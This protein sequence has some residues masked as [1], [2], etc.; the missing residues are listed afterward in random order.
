MKSSE[1]QVV[2]TIKIPGTTLKTRPV[3]QLRRFKG[4]SEHLTDSNEIYV[5]LEKN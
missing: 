1:Q 5:K 4:A 3:T 2:E